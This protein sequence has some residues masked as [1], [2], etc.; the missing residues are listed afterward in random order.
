[1]A[2]FH[3]LQIALIIPKLFQT[4]L[5]IFNI[6]LINKKYRK[7]PWKE[8][9]SFHKFFLVGMMGWTVYIFLD[10]FIYTLAGLSMDPTTQHGSYQGYDTNYPSLFF[11]NV[12]RDIGFIASLIMSWC[13]LLAAF[14]L[15]YD[16]ERLM[17]VFTRNILTLITMAIITL[18]IAGGDFIQITISDT[19]ASVSGVFNEFG[20]VAIFLNVLIFVLSAIWLFLTLK[21]VTNKETSQA[22]KN[23]IR[24]FMWGVLFM[25]FGHIYWLLLGLLASFYPTFLLLPEL[26]YYIVGHAFWTISPIFI[27]MG[28]GR[29]KYTGETENN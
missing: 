6:F 11:V 10:I 21:S 5:F 25:G 9:P 19:G 20:A 27:Y 26:V 28:F 12:L 16:E 14:S 7:T 18:V 13:Y 23:R 3:N 15:R 22:F 17:S 8:R 29:N 4:I 24:F 1:M 2:V